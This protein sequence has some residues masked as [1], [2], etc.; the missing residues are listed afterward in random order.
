MNGL[1]IRELKTNMENMGFYVAGAD[2]RSM[3]DNPLVLASF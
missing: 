3:A 2:A 1:R